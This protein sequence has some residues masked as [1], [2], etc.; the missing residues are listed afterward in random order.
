MSSSGSWA[1]A[2]ALPLVQR[3]AT[4]AFFIAFLAWLDVLPIPW[5]EREADGVVSFNYHPLCMTL[6]FV[7]LMPEAVIAY[8]DGEVTGPC[9]TRT[10]RVHAALHVLATTH[11]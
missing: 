5:F 2:S 1:S 6:A 9:P 11:W 8:A 3:T 4:V 7:L 10:R